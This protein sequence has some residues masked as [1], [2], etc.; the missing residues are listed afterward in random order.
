M[1]AIA[2]IALLL[3]AAVSPARAGE[4]EAVRK[5][6]L[7][8]RECL[9]KYGG[10]SDPKKREEAAAR[11]AEIDLRGAVPEMLVSIRD[12]QRPPITQ[13]L[14]V[15]RLRLLGEVPALAPSFAWR[16]T[17]PGDR[18][19]RDEAHAAAVSAS[20]DVARRWYEQCAIRDMGVRRTLALERIGEIAS[21]DSVPVVAT[22]LAT[23]GLDVHVQLSKLRSID[24]VPLNLGSAGGAA[25]NVPV[26]LPSIDLVEA[27][28]HAAVPAAVEESWRTASLGALRAIAGRDLGE[29][30]E[31]Y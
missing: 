14:C 25:T 27:Q 21:P 6:R 23:V 26:E 20:A 13:R 17:L 22:I 4:A 31:A 5:A 15:S 30:P 19:L 16:A 8:A 24:S 28:M 2:L 11:L 3:L 18:A 29:K 10:T 1:R 7:A 12:N 9:R